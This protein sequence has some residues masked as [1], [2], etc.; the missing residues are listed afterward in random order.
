MDYVLDVGLPSFRF[1][2]KDCEHQ[3]ASSV[4][5]IFRAVLLVPYTGLVCFLTGQAVIS[6]LC[7]VI[8]FVL[9]FLGF[10]VVIT[11]WFPHVVG[12]NCSACRDLTV[13]SHHLRDDGFDCSLLSLDLILGFVSL[14]FPR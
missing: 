5:E 13:P 11:R 14:L 7:H 10:R 1:A 12:K 2:I 6:G 3:V 8:G 4:L 9:W